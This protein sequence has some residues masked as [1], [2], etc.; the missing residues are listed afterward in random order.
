MH[1][2]LRI[3]GINIFIAVAAVFFL[4]DIKIAGILCSAAAVVLSVIFILSLQKQLVKIKEYSNKF[5][6]GDLT[7][8]S[9]NIKG[10]YELRAVWTSFSEFVTYFSTMLIDIK[11]IT[12][13]NNEVKLKMQTATDESVSAAEEINS[14]VTNIDS[15]LEKLVTNLKRSSEAIK[16]LSDSVKRFNNKVEDQASAV[17]QSS[18][19]IEEMT[20]SIENVSEISTERELSSKKLVELTIRGSESLDASGALIKDNSEDVQEVL[21]IISIINNIASQTDLLSMNAAIEAA[22]A[23]DAGRG[24]AVVA[25]EIRGLAESTNANS[26]QIRKTINKIAER[27]N[28]VLEASISSRK[29]FENIETENVNSSKAMAEISSTMSELAEGSREIRDAVLSIAD[30]TKELTDESET[31]SHSLTDADSAISSIENLGRQISQGVKEIHAGFA[32]VS[33]SVS[34]LKNTNDEGSASMEVL[35][36]ELQ[37]FTISEP[38]VNMQTEPEEL[39]APERKTTYTD[40]SKNE[41][42]FSNFKENDTVLLDK[43][44]N[45]SEEKTAVISKNSG[46]DYD[47]MKPVKPSSTETGVKEADT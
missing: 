21:D 31:F 23:G 17:A 37:R 6:K 42:S 9:E 47:S 22:H 25:E 44:F 15:M 14:N 27:I 5:A 45:T 34:E 11:H 13:L 41:S 4:V 2:K 33:S 8:V 39:H 36:R 16:N 26:K 40:S 10:S 19:A 12:I 29:I 28:K 32:E 38:D 43:S 46:T 20:A 3:L 35:T 24:F 1:I 18:A 30:G 7:R